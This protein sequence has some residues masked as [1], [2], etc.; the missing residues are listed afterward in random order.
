MAP[1]LGV[2]KHSYNAFNK[3]QDLPAKAL[4]IAKTL[5]VRF[6][7]FGIISS[8]AF[9]T[10]L[11]SSWIDYKVFWEGAIARHQTV[12]FNI[13]SH[14]LPTKLSY[15]LLQGDRQEIQRTLDSNYGVFG[16]VVTNCKIAEKECPD[17]YILL[18]SKS[19]QNWKATLKLADLPNYPYDV[20][21]N[22]PPLMA[23]WKYN[24]SGAREPNA[25]GNIN[26]GEIIGRVYYIPS[27]QPNF[28]EDY[29]HGIKNPLH[30]SDARKNYSLKL[31]IFLVGGFLLWVSLEYFLAKNQSLENSNRQTKQQLELQGKLTEQREQQLAQEIQE[32]THK[33]E[34]IIQ[35]NLNLKNNFDAALKREFSYQKEVDDLLNQL[36]E[37]ESKQAQLLNQVESLRA[38]K[39][40]LIEQLSQTDRK[41]KN[42]QRSRPG[43]SEQKQGKLSDR[44]TLQVDCLKELNNFQSKEFK[45]LILRIIG[46]PEQPRPHDCRPLNKYGHR[47]VYSV[48]EGEFRIC[49]TIHKYPKQPTGEIRV[50]LVGRRNDDEIYKALRRLIG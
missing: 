8:A 11:F 39:D 34:K 33:T 1:E 37:E 47:D 20:L 44:Y 3:F 25:T 14:T 10:A 43:T 16:L 13:L 26:S 4:R 29:W 15:A 7:R 42:I 12:N 18:S 30:N 6:F 38:E 27:I 23:Q 28:L 46:L 5:R 49:Y 21:Q 22:P 17:Q 35:Q 41:L 36:V 19:E 40:R 45:Q 32:L 50:L 9:C 24:S 2:L 31:G 48:D